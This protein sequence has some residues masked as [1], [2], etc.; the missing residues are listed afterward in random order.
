M[1]AVRLSSTGIAILGCGTI[2]SAVADMLLHEAAHLR[3]AVGAD[4]GAA[5]CGGDQPGTRA[6]GGDSGAD[7][8]GQAGGGAGG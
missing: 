4:A 5:A 2:G 6:G 7:L 3:A 1:P 8:D